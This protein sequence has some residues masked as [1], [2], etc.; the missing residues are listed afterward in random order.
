[1]GKKSVNWYAVELFLTICDAGGIT[2]AVKSGTAKISQPALSAQML[3]LEE[4]VGQ[5]L[6]ERKPFRLTQDGLLFRSEFEAI[7]HRMHESLQKI[8]HQNQ[9]VLRIA[10]S[11]LVISKHLPQLIEHMKMPKN[12]RLLLKDAQ[13]HQL[14]A[15]VSEGVVDL[16]IGVMPAHADRGKSPLAEVLMQVPVG[17]L[18]KKQRSQKISDWN[19][20]KALILGKDAP[21]LICLPKENLISDHVISSLRKKSIPWPITVEVS[22]LSHVATYVS[23]GLGYGI[24]LDH[25]VADRDKEFDWIPFPTNIVAPIKIG[26]W[27]GD[28]PPLLAKQF[29]Q[30][31]RYYT[32]KMVGKI[33]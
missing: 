9:E 20:L 32:Q 2:A 17:I 33:K 6:F 8:K 11:D 28:H 5:V 23:L 31:A 13:S 25:A 21:S 4:M 29:M 14:P 3:A 1:M 19:N 10:A 15:L 24:S 7:R 16:A 12:A 30:T 27:Y 22:S 18:I 26:M